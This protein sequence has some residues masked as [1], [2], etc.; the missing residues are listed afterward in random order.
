MSLYYTHLLIPHLPEYRPEPD[1]VAAFGQGM[2]NN[3]NIS[4][5]FTISFSRVAKGESPGRKLRN[6]MTGETITIPSPSRRIE[7]PE[8]LSSLSQFIEHAAGQREYD[9][10]I[11]GEGVPPAPPLAIGYV[12]NDTWN[13]MAG[14]YHLEIRFRV[15]SN[16]VRLYLLESENDLHRP[17]DLSKFRPRFGEDCSVGEREGIFVH[18]ESGAIRI[19]NAGCGTFWIE[20]KF[21]KFIFPRLRDHGVNTLD[22]S[23]VTLARRAFN[24]DFVQAC[25][26]G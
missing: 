5:P 7:K 18:P 6:P 3:G 26:W 22:D 12:E 15:R 11:S 13:P 25:D 24:C 9:I 20:F 17:P 19:P 8:T 16:I 1:A 23:I 4:S 21:G 14:A 10:A 2:I